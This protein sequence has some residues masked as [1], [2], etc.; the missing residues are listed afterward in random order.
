M[1][2]KSKI[3]DNPTIKRLKRDLEGLEALATVYAFASGIGLVQ[4]DYTEHLAQLPMMRK[5]LEEMETLADRF[6]THFATRGWI[7]Y[8][9][10]DV[11]LMKQVVNLADSGELDEAEELLVEFYDQEN[12]RLLLRLLRGIEQFRPREELARLALEDH[13]AGRYHASVPVVLSIIDGFVND[14]ASVG[15]F[16]KD[17]DLT[18]WDSVAGHVTGLPS[19]SKLFSAS[20]DRTSSEQIEIP[21]RNGILHGRD[22]GYA[23]KVVAAKTW[24]ALW[25]IREWAL[26]VRNGMKDPQPEE[27]PPSWG[28]TFSLIAKNNEFKRHLEA[29]KPRE[30][31][32]GIDFPTS[33][34]PSLFREGSP[35]RVAVEFLHYWSKKNYGNMANLTDR[36]VFKPI[37]MLA[38]E[39]RKL[40]EDKELT[41][42]EILSIV[43]K[44]AIATEIRVRTV[45][46][47]RGS[48]GVREDVIR[49]WHQDEKG[50]PVPVETKGGKWRILQLSLDP[51]AYGIY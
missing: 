42:F 27:K 6:N 31:Q 5:Q 36:V 50:D 48:T 44:G 29:W 51:I 18:A 19:L 30:L 8:D 7:A 20:R 47:Y 1:E 17:V 28:E 12:L 49:V 23:N 41:G 4:G 37:K 11:N 32:V 35:E 25:A 2:Q 15:F 14:F 10:L 21:F 38:G 39:M 22:L 45:A 26:A 43:D 3:S 33:G 46:I 24:A 16:A 9:F 34:D 40:F 13:L